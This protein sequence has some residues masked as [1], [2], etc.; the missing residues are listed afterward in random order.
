MTAKL[1]ATHEDDLFAVGSMIFGCSSTPVDH[2]LHYAE[3]IT[4]CDLL[5]YLAMLKSPYVVIQV[6]EK[7]RSPMDRELYRIWLNNYLSIIVK[8]MLISETN[9]LLVKV[10]GVLW[11]NDSRSEP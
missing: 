7:P 3:G 2:T 10:R 4:R 11:E 1:E 9:V 6:S 5:D 8:I